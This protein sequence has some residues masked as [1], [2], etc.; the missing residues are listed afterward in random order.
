M[1]TVTA[2]TS[3]ISAELA[4][5]YRTIRAGIA[6]DGIDNGLFNAS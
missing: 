6:Q 1:V 3:V 2:W 5:T 4:Q